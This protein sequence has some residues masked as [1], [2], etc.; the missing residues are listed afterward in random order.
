MKNFQNIAENRIPDR[1]LCAGCVPQSNSSMGNFCGQLQ[2]AQGD[3]PDR[4]LLAFVPIVGAPI[5]YQK[6][7]GTAQLAAMHC[8]LM[9]DQSL[10]FCFTVTGLRGQLNI[11]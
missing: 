5:A 9:P 3:I 1:V 2:D 4:H 10:Q 7:H 8:W 11:G 6:C